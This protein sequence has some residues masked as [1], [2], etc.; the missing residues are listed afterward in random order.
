MDGNTLFYRS[1]VAKKEHTCTLCGGTIRTGETYKVLGFID[2]GK[3]WQEKLHLRCARLVENF[4][5]QDDN[6]DCEWTKQWVL[7]DLRQQLV[8]KAKDDGDEVLYERATDARI[9]VVNTAL[10]DL[11]C[12]VFNEGK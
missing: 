9:G 2:L 3:L 6:T 12:E 10:V 8:D 4:C 11:Y 1:Q 5:A 7:E